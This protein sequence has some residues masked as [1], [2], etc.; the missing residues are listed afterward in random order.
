MKFRT[1]RQNRQCIAINILLNKHRF[2][3]STP[4]TPKK[5]ERWLYCLTALTYAYSTTRRESMV[6]CVWLVDSLSIKVTILYDAQ[7]DT[8]IS[9]RRVYTMHIKKHSC[10]VLPAYNKVS[11]LLNENAR[12]YFSA[13][14]VLR[15]NSKFYKEFLSVFLKVFFLF[16]IFLTLNWS[17]TV[18]IRFIITFNNEYF[19]S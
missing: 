15:T 17:F 4:V 5:R 9:L 2:Y 1:Y 8:L 13:I 14:I 10:A 6:L 11:I 12:A 16:L 19:N 7:E 3:L 18:L